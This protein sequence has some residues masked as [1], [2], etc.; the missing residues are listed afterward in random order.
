MPISTPMRQLAPSTR[1][2]IQKQNQQH[3]GV[4]PQ[5]GS[6]CF[7]NLTTASKSRK[8]V[9]SLCYNDYAMKNKKEK[10][11]TWI[12][13]VVLSVSSIKC[14]FD[15]IEGP[16]FQYSSYWILRIIILGSILGTLWF[17]F[18]LIAFL[19]RDKIEQLS[20]IV[21]LLSMLFIPIHIWLIYS[22]MHGLD[23]LNSRLGP[24]VS[25]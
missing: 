23:Q 8:I 13:I 17:S 7:Q 6:L 20:F 21:Y 4:I 2:Q 3:K 9:F 16:F 15:I 5:H 24:R 14:L 19:I 10:W 1:S 11:L 25:Y 12:T 18:M 22:Y